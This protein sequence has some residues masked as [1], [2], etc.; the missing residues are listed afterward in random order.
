MKTLCFEALLKLEPA[1]GMPLKEGRIFV[2]EEK[3]PS[4]FSYYEKT[5]PASGEVLARVLLKRP[6]DL[7]WNDEFDFSAKSSAG[8]SGRGRVL[9]PHPDRI[10]KMSAEKRVKLLGRL[11]GNEADMLSALCRERGVQGLTETELREFCRLDAE[12][13]ELLSRTLEAEG[14]VK[15]LAFSPLFLLSTESFDFLLDKLTDFLVQFHEKHPG[16]RGI[17]RERVEKL[18]GLGPRLMALVVGALVRAGKIREFGDRIALSSHQPRLTPLEEKILARL[19]EMSFKGEF[20][21]L[22]EEE[23]RREFHLT[24]RA[25]EKMLGLLLE[26]K[27]VVQT[28]DGMILHARWLDEIVKKIRALGKR[29]LTVFEFKEMTGLSRKYAIPLLELLDRMR[30]TRR[31]GPGR[32]IL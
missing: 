16:D 22:S 19:E 3:C 12:R 13:L 11:A 28:E 24:A 14:S 20:Q 31:K 7:K 30:V 23:I 17:L 25:A 2:R 32:E 10:K 9:H 27:K 26:R 15:I 1:A 6:L 18:F 4:T 29:D 21:S 8:L 5:F